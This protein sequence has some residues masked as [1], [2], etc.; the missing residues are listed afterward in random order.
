M[1]PYLKNKV[2]RYIQ[3]IYAHTFEFPHAFFNFFSLALKCTDLLP[4]YELGTFF[5]EH[6]ASLRNFVIVRSFTFVY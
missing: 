6:A 2:N 5:E 1:F 3:Y 4:K